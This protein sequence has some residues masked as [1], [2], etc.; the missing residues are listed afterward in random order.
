MKSPTTATSPELR[1]TDFGESLL[2]AASTIYDP[3]VFGDKEQ[4]YLLYSLGGEAG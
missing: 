3:A 1:T 2:S 4:I